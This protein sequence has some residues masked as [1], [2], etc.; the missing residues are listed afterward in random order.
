LIKSRRSKNKSKRII[1]TSDPPSKEY[2]LD[3][4]VSL[5]IRLAVR[6]IRA[7]KVR[8]MSELAGGTKMIIPM[9][10]A[11]KKSI[12]TNIMIYYNG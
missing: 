5:K 2:F 6:E 3:L 8:M 11:I 10:T 9:M 12:A 7:I 4:V 1:K